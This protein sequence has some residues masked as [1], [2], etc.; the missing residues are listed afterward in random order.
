MT[1]R[2]QWRR[3]IGAMAVAAGLATSIAGPDAL[4][5]DQGARQRG[6]EI[7]ASDDK[8]RPAIP[9]EASPAP[10]ELAREGLAKMLQA[11]DKLIESMPQ[12]QMPEITENGDIILRRKRPEAAPPAPVPSKPNPPDKRGI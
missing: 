4:A 1:G 11:L 2:R 12:Y 9:P 10:G 3:T 5:W 6:Q 8:D 7:A